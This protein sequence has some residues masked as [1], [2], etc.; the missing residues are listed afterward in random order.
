MNAPTQSGNDLFRILLYRNDVKEI[1]LV[2]TWEGFSL[3][4]MPIPPHRRVAEELTAAIRSAWNLET[5]CLFPLPN[6][7]PPHALVHDQVMEIGHPEADTPARM[8]WFTVDLLSAGSFQSPSDFA[9]I[10]DSRTILDRYGRNE[11]PGAFAKPGW[12]RTVTEWVEGQASCV[13]LRATGKFR[14]LNASPSFSLI[15]F[16]TD[17]PALWFKAVGEPNVREF[18][19]T[20]TLA[21]LLPVYLPEIRATRAE[22]NAWLMTEFAGTHPHANSGIDTWIAVAETLAEMQIASSGKTI[23]LLGAGCHDTRVCCLA[24]KI[25]PFLEA[26]TGLMVQQTKASPSPMSAAE[27]SALGVQLHIICSNLAQSGIPNALSHLDLNPGNILVSDSQCVF[28]DWAEAC[29]GHPFV[30]FE[31]LL[32]H[33]RKLLPKDDALE[34]ELSSVYTAP[35]RRLADRQAIAEA[36]AAAPLL[37]VFTCAVAAET[38]R[39]ESRRSQPNIAALLRS[40]TRRMK[41]EADSFE[42]RRVTCMP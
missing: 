12:L 34:A 28:L 35:W 7:V 10:Q 41:R 18:S 9:A 31:Y 5:Y 24:E 11:L 21:N 2:T 30:A 27:L 23:H 6:G 15:R 16:E 40:L 25:D 32:E 33:L 38:W 19:I 20:R 8:Q 42:K 22:W 14:Q 26:M 1:L 4:V 3:P 17:G 13:G 39:D 37:A 29:V 36:I